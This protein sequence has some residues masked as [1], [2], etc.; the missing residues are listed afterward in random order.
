M[1]TEEVHI[2]QHFIQNIQRLPDGR[3]SVTLPKKDI[4]NYTSVLNINWHFIPPRA[5]SF[6]GLWENAVKNF[7]KIFKVVTFDKTFNFEEMSTFSAQIEAILNSRPL[8]PLSEDPQDLHY[9]S[10]GH[11]LIGRPLTALPFLNPPTTHQDNRSRWKILQNVTQDLWDRWSKEYLVT[12]QRKNKFLSTQDNVTVDTM[13]L[14]KDIGSVPS[15]WRLARVVD[16]HPGKDGKVRVV[17]V[18]TTTGRFKRAISSIA[19]LP[20]FEEED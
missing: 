8:V 3:F 11:F 10:P 7:K 9:I 12:L 2:E 18:Q 13:V 17:T 15:S 4:Y 5:P 14:L 1:P 6:G 19:P 20:S 16:T